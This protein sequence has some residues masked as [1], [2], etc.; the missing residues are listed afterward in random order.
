MATLKKMVVLMVWELGIYDQAYNVRMH[1]GADKTKDLVIK[2]EVT[3]FITTV[4]L[5]KPSGF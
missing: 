3:Y 4:L 2:H 5:L 1:I